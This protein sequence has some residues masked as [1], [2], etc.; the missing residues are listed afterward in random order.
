MYGT[1]GKLLGADAGKQEGDWKYSF[2]HYIFRPYNEVTGFHAPVALAPGERE[3]A[4][5]AQ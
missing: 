4:S 3:L 2:S 1:C 5:I